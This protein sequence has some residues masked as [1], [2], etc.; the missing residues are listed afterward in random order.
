MAQQLTRRGF[1][2][3]YVVAGGAK[4]WAA[5]KLRTKPWNTPAALLPS[6]VTVE[7]VMG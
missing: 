5:A 2:K 3:V 4:A 7:S 1:K 6:S